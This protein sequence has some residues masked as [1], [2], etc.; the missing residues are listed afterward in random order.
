MELY[1]SRNDTTFTAKVV[2]TPEGRYGVTAFFSKEHQIKIKTMPRT[3]KTLWRLLKAA[4]A[5]GIFV[6]TNSANI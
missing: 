1:F 6:N 2:L 4:D 3:Y 5:K